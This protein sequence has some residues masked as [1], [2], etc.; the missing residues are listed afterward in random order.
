MTAS[1][2]M[3]TVTSA[4]RTLSASASVKTPTKSVSSKVSSQTT[5]DKRGHS[6]SVFEYLR[7]LQTENGLSVKGI[8]KTTN[9]PAVL[10]PERRSAEADAERG[11][12]EGSED[13]QLCASSTDGCSTKSPA[14]PGT[15]DPPD[16]V[17]TSNSPSH[18]TT[19][20]FRVDVKETYQF[21][22]LMNN[23]ADSMAIPECADSFEASYQIQGALDKNG[24][25][26]IPVNF[27][28]QLF[29]PENRESFNEFL[30]DAI[31][32]FLHEVQ[33]Q[34]DASRQLLKLSRATSCY[35]ESV[36]LRRRVFLLMCAI[37]PDLTFQTHFDCTSPHMER[38]LD[39]IIEVLIEK[40]GKEQHA[41][42]DG[43]EIDVD[44]SIR[45]CYVDLCDDPVV[46]LS[47]LK[48]K[49]LRVIQLLLPQLQLPEAF[50]IDNDLSSLLKS[51]TDCA[52]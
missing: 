5:V 6:D 29:L 14:S 51:I 13:Q 17:P 42:F 35:E 8:L 11:P 18:S 4:P 24:A 15:G 31:D 48:E 43:M 2:Q 21:A 3:L 19:D 45:D 44:H 12:Q 32:S 22:F 40:A 38:F 27:E 34:I 36:A 26:D 9:G 37:L 49:I 33:R 23:D 1:N 25:M 39:Y 47:K 41:E 16:P 30:R 52:R 10:P 28:P 20:V 46:C 50:D 7:E